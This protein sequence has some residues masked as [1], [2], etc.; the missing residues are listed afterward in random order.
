MESNGTYAL[1]I[2]SQSRQKLPVGRFGPCDFQPGYYIYSGSAL[3]GLK[4]RLKRHFR[5]DKRLHWHI[6][7]L[8]QYTKIVEV[9][10]SMSEERLECTWNG[11]VAALHGAVPHI[12]GFGSSDCRCYT[13]LTYFSSM[14]SFDEFSRELRARGLPDSC[15]LRPWTALC[16]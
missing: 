10:Y 12:P 5:A 9:W 3:G 11:I 1:V 8:L 6:D 16:N 13:H 4:G 7:Y 14:P 15:R 2:H